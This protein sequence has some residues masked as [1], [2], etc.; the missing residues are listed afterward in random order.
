M[1]DRD[2]KE[3]E[4]P[5]DPA[6][7]RIRRKLARLLIASFGVMFLGLIAIF[8]VIVYRLNAAPGDAGLSADAH[9]VPAGDATIR[10][11]AGARL[12][13]TALDG[14]RA[15][16]Q[17]ESSAGAEL[18]L[19]DLADGAILARYDLASECSE[20]PDYRY[21][22]VLRANRRRSICRPRCSLRLAVQDVALSRRKQ[23][24]DSPRERHT[25]H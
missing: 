14:G 12:V 1:V 11:P 22:S 9:R 24:F 10:L 21:P 3:E 17:V 19:V 20:A 25:L 5:L 23:G 15:L 18:V 2:R 6:V 4:A 13:S 16:L 7:E 8:A